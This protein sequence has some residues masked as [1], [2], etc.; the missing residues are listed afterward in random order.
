MSPKSFELFYKNKPFRLGDD[1][2]FEDTDPLKGCKPNKTVFADI[3]TKP[4]IL[5]FSW[6]TRLQQQGTFSNQVYL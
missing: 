5:K 4:F 6:K 3:V 2:M 1:S